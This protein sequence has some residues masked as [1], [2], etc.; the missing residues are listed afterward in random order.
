M[1]RELL[2]DLLT[3]GYSLEAIGER[4]GLHPSTVAYWVRKHGLEPAHRAKHEPRG[5]D[6][7]RVRELAD[8]GLSVRAMA[9]ELGVS[10]TTVR[11]WLRRGGLQSSRS[12]RR[13]RVERALDEG[14]TRVELTCR[15]HGECEFVREGSGYFRCT[16]CRAERVAERRRQV[17]AKLVAEAGGRC[18]LCGYD[19]CQSALQFHHVDPG[20]KTFAIS[21]RGATR[22][23]ARAREEAAK[24]VLLCANCHAEVEAGAG[25]VL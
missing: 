18:V 23:L 16:R 4:I 15:K 6:E 20:G 3:A 12:A 19:R 14:A 7:T 8:A 17:K 13:Q 21:S 22:A 10:Y 25:A 2:V 11:H 1:E 5:V 9:T 24:C